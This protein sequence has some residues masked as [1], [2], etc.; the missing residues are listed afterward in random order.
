MGLSLLISENSFFG[1]KK[2]KKKKK[3]KKTMF[4]IQDLENERKNFLQKYAEHKTALDKDVKDLSQFLTEYVN[5]NKSILSD[6][7]G[8]EELGKISIVE[9]KV[10][11]AENVRLKEGVAKLRKWQKE[12]VRKDSKKT[13]NNFVKK[14]FKCC[15]IQGR[16]YISVPEIEVLK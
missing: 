3:K 6:H 2:G 11:Q 13:E 10:L 12:F 8:D 7:D 1:G 9:I 16:G 4:R 14:V 5:K 15:D